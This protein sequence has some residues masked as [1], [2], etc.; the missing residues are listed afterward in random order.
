[1]S[2]ENPFE[3]LFRKPTPEEKLEHAKSVLSHQ[4]KIENLC[5]AALP[6]IREIRAKSHELVSLGIEAPHLYKL[7]R[8]VALLEEEVEATL[9][10]PGH[11]CG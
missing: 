4:Q 5:K 7:R 2:D 3:K 9:H 8:N 10:V 6:I 11:Q 1:M